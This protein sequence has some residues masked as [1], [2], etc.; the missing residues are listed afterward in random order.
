[1]P[2]QELYK[3]AGTGVGDRIY[4]IELGQELETGAVYRSRNKSRRQELN[5]GAKILA[6]DRSWRQELCL[7]AGI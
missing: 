4:I 7:G 6:G 5:T 2:G 3:G 1:M